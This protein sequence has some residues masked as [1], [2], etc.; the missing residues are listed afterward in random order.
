MPTRTIAR[1]SFSVLEHIMHH[2][3]PAGPVR[4][5]C[6]AANQRIAATTTKSDEESELI[7]LRWTSRSEAVSIAADGASLVREDLSHASHHD[8]FGDRPGMGRRS[9]YI[10]PLG[11]FVRVSGT[12]PHRLSRRETLDW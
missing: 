11:E 8:Q 12:D 7:R 2:P 3:P 1:T 9:R 5:R 10:S 6:S 4:W